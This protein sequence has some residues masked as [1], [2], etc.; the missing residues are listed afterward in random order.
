MH[1]KKDISIMN[2]FKAVSRCKGDIF[3]HT[4]EQDCLNLKSQLCQYVFTASFFQ[5]NIQKGTII[6]E[7][8]SD[9]DHLADYLE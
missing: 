3:Y 6:C 2:F 9:Y 8:Q 7:L 4:T 5:S 1:L